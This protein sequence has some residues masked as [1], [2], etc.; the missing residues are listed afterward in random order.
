MFSFDFLAGNLELLGSLARIW[1]LYPCQ[2]LMLGSWGSS[3]VVASLFEPQ[4]SP[5]TTK[6][7]MD[8]F[9][10]VTII[11]LIGDPQESLC[12]FIANIS[13]SMDTFRCSR[14]TNKYCIAS[15]RLKEELTLILRL[16]ISNLSPHDI[17]DPKTLLF[18]H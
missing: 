13:V 17:A 18:T 9:N 2:W 14:L 16:L 8:L 4:V 10:Q 7:R 12:R 15:S 11:S 1:A 5:V 3:T 6:I